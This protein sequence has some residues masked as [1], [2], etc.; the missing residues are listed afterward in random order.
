MLPII[1]KGLRREYGQLVTG[2]RTE[3]KQARHCKGDEN[4]RLE[5]VHVRSLYCL[6]MVGF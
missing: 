5:D 4:E 2:L 6:C 3:E 1:L